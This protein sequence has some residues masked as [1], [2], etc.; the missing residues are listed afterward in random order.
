MGCGAGSSWSNCCLGPNPG[1]CFP[2]QLSHH[3]SGYPNPPL[4]TKGPQRSRESLSVSILQTRNGG[5]T[6]RPWLPDTALDITSHWNNLSASLGALAPRKNTCLPRTPSAPTLAY[7][8]LA[9]FSCYGHSP[10]LAETMPKLQAFNP[11]LRPTCLSSQTSISTPNTWGVLDGSL[12]PNTILDISHPGA[13]AYVVPSTGRP[14]L[15]L[16]PT[17][18]PWLKSFRAPSA[19][20][21]ESPALSCTFPEHLPHPS[22]DSKRHLNPS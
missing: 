16:Y 18:H 5:R 9:I 17:A 14:D 1:S 7:P 3:L 10:C 6:Q 8:P 20:S 12:I 4:G 21:Q 11:E 13:S 19:S 22:R 2:A 15:V